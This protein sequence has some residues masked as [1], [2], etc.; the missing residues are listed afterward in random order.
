MRV[1]GANA[2]GP[3]WTDWAKRRRRG[4]RVGEHC[5]GDRRS[6]SCRRLSS[7]TAGPAHAGILDDFRRDFALTPVVW[8]IRSSEDPRAAALAEGLR[9]AAT[10][11]GHLPFDSLSPR[12]GELPRL[13]LPAVH[14]CAA[15]D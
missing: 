2:P 5:P 15:L 1:G 7:S 11:A 3:A 14:V 9:R 12:A 10:A 6:V 4:A 13:W 8:S